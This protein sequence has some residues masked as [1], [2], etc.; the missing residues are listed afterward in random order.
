MNILG[1]TVVAGLDRVIRAK[2]VPNCSPWLQVG[3]V[4]DTLARIITFHIGYRAGLPNG[5]ITVGIGI[6]F[7]DQVEVRP[8]QAVVQLPAITQG[9][10]VFYVGTGLH[11]KA[12]VQANI[13]RLAI[14]NGHCIGWFKLVTDSLTTKSHN[15]VWGNI[16]SET[17]FHAIVHN[18]GRPVESILRS[19]TKVDTIVIIAKVERGI[20]KK[21]VAEDVIPAQR[22][23]RV[24]PA[25][26]RRITKTKII[27]A[28]VA[29][30]KQLVIFVEFV[31]GLQRQVI[32][33]QGG[34]AQVIIEERRSQ[35]INVR[36][37]TSHNKTGLILYNRRFHRQAAKDYPYTAINGE[38]LAV[39]FLHPH[40]QNRR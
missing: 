15:V 20:G 33:V 14:T 3:I 9:L 31:I 30:Q 35:Y 8:T 37:A 5:C 28:K 2:L 16:I 17:G 11:R 4:L 6:A 38:A 21:L 24:P 34:L 40:I 1:R 29:T 12:F 10:F 7:T 26:A 39:A 23:S 19:I 27:T 18:L 32:K 13:N 36:A 22:G 25:K